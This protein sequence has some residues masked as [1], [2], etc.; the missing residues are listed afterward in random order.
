[1]TDEQ[2]AWLRELRLLLP[3]HTVEGKQNDDGIFKVRVSTEIL[4]WVD[5]ITDLSLTPAARFAGKALA[6]FDRAPKGMS[7]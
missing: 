1:M 6:A 3:G 7:R 5:T 2:Q 4:A